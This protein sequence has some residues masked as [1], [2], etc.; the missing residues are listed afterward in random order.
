MKFLT[1]PIEIWAAVAV[2]IVVKLQTSNRLTLLG[3]VSTVIVAMGSS[4]LLYVPITEMMGWGA[5]AHV[6]VAVILAL[7]AENLMKAIVEFTADRGMM[8]GVIKHIVKK[9]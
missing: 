3:V 1:Y 7:T 6:V 9:N 2:A 5:D 4:L 8:Q